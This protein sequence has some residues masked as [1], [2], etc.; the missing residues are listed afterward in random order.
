MRH[1]WGL[2]VTLPSALFA[3]SSVM[4]D[5]TPPAQ[6]GAIAVVTPVITVTDAD[7]G[8]PICDAVVVAAC[9][10]AGATLSAYGPDGYLVDA[11][12]EGCHYGPTLQTV[13]SQSATLTISQPG[14][15]TKTVSVETR[16]SGCPGPIPEAQQ[17]NVAL[18]HGS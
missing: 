6:C 1:R 15:E 14:Y 2:A 10:D 18:K 4:G 8:S 5:P 12:V 9:G 16:Y 17:V 11:S 3:C 7:T 13:C